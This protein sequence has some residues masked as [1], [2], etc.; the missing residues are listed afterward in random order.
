MLKFLFA[1]VLSFTI[2]NS[3]A[4][5]ANK[6]KE[7]T[8]NIKTLPSATKEKDI[9]M[10]KKE[11]AERVSRIDKETSEIIIDEES[12]IQTVDTPFL[13]DGK[14][15]K[16]VIFAPTNLI[17]IYIGVVGK[18]F[19]ALIGGDEDKYFEF[20]EKGEINI[21][22]NQLRIAYLVSFLEITKT[23][24]ERFQI[25]DSISDI[26][27]RPNLSEEQE[28]KFIEFQDKY[29]S[30]I[31]PP[32]QLD[33]GNYKVFVIKGQDLVEYELTITEDNLIKAKDSILEK[34]LL[35]PYAF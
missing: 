15:Y 29:K 33:S 10:D 22:N 8:G 20:A 18:D 28:Q 21:Q 25:I 9:V 24:G 26:E 2:Q 23:D 32:K 19:T 17:E 3:C 35:I 13:K 31:N 11:L 7:D 1:V 5:S 27:K 14:I 34:D 4:N 6:I 12:E 30:I 16:V